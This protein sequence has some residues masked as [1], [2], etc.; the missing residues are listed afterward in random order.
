MR[1]KIPRSRRCWFCGT[2]LRRLQQHHLIH[3]LRGGDHSPAN[4]ANACLKCSRFKGLMTVH[5]FRQVVAIVLRANGH[6]CDHVRFHGEGGPTF[7]WPTRQ[8]PNVGRRLP[9]RVP[10]AASSVAG[11]IPCLWCDAW[12]PPRELAHH[13]PRCPRR[14]RKS[15]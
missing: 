7:R 13:Q 1:R 3:V 4:L 9:E 5:E 6:R 10:I 15:P 12:L 11:H 8:L 14:P 2:G